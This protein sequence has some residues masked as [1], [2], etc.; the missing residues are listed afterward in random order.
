MA[1]RDLKPCPFC[2]FSANVLSISKPR[3]SQ[4]DK[5]ETDHYEVRCVKCTA[6]VRG[7][8]RGKVIEAWNRRASDA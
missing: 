3:K 6:N 5:L 2:G 7:K 4:F 8:Y 1:M